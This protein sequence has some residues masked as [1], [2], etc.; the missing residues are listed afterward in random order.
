[1]FEPE[2][3]CDGGYSLSSAETSTY[4]FTRTFTVETISLAVPK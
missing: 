3:H 1:M 4:M 2:K